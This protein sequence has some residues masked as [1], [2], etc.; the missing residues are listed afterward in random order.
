MLRPYFTAAER[1]RAIEAGVDPSLL[2]ETGGGKIRLVA[3]PNGEGY[4]CPAFDVHTQH[5]RIYSVRPLDCRLYPLALMRDAEGR[6][7]VLGL[8]SK[9]PY[10]REAANE[11]RLANYA[12]GVLGR[13]HD[14]ALAAL[15]A[16]NPDLVNLNQDDVR[17][18]G[19]VVH[20][21]S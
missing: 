5:C 6:G 8:D 1:E 12:S 2:P 21:G 15:L 18:V 14:P 11:P 20:E 4:V 13:L 10:V 17:P 9:C 7:L 19:E 3:H 16:S